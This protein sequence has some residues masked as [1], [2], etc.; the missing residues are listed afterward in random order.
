MTAVV[1]GW[2][3]RVFHVKHICPLPEAVPSIA[4]RMF[5]VKRG[6]GRSKG[7]GR[8]GTATAR[9]VGGRDVS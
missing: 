1:M 4:G 7:V 2:A 8:D 5:H 3:K 6:L 9:L